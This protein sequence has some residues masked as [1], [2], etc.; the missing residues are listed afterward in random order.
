MKNL[1]SLAALWT[2]I[3]LCA[4]CQKEITSG[5]DDG[6]V[7]V[8]FTVQTGDQQT[9]AIADAS[10][11]DILHWEIYGDNVESAQAAM[12]KGSVKDEDKDGVFTLD[13]SVILDQTYHF[14][15]WAQVDREEGTEHYDVSDLRKVRIMSYD[16]ELAND[17]SRAAFFAYETIHVAGSIDE[18]ITLYRPFAQLNLGTETYDVS[19]LNLTEPLKVNESE[20]KV[21]GLADTFN[22]LTA[23]DKKNKVEG[24]EHLEAAGYLDVR[25]W[26]LATFPEIKEYHD[27]HKQ[28]VQAILA[29]A[30]N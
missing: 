9:R 29:E 2:M 21:Y 1:L 4:S 12:A 19:S 23:Q 22:T 16:D 17:E 5:I 8:S 11:I 30:A 24:A 3:L 26:F 10:N 28:K 15:F 20:I 14:I 6:G 13:L 18:T 7:K 25:A 27:S